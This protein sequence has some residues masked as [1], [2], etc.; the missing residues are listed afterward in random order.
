MVISPVTA[1]RPVARTTAPPSTSSRYVATMPPW[2][3][4]YGPRKHAGITIGDTTPS[5]LLK[6]RTWSPSRCPGPQ[7]KH[8]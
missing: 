5:E 3:E 7:P 8:S 2:A 6:H 4:P 1:G